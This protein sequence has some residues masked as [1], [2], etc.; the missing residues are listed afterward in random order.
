[1]FLL[2]QNEPSKV[3]ETLVIAVATEPSGSS[4]ID[5]INV[6]MVPYKISALGLGP[7]VRKPHNMW[8]IILL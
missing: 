7:T 3:L 1:M 2:L 5:T 6:S 4:I 8:L